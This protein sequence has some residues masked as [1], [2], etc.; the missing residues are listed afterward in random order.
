MW[1]C[2]GTEPWT[3]T[4]C[5]LRVLSN[6]LYSQTEILLLIHLFTDDHVNCAHSLDMVENIARNMGVWPSSFWCDN[7]DSFDQKPRRHTTELYGNS[8]VFVA[9][10]TEWKPC[11]HS[12]HWHNFFFYSWQTFI[13]FPILDLLTCNSTKNTHEFPSLHPCQ[14]GSFNFWI[15]NHLRGGRNV[16]LSLVFSYISLTIRYWTDTSICM[17][18]EKCLQLEFLFCCPSPI[19]VVWVEIRASH[20]QWI[21]PTFLFK[22]LVFK[23]KK[24]LR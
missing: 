12:N 1:G 6:E 5:L 3:W 8:F 24:K 15:I 2:S 21:T 20:S 4:L 14:Y 13:L 11:T 18:S 7:F 9:L 17:S 10:E 16:S 22:L 23:K 19:F